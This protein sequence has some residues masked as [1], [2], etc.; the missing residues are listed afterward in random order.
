MRT[1]LRV[2]IIACSLLLLIAAA[3]YLPGYR[4]ATASV[5]VVTANTN[6]EAIGK[7]ES[8]AA[9]LKIYA[10][11]KGFNSER[12]F[13][14]DMS[15]PSGKQRFFVYNFSTDKIEEAGLVTHGSGSIT[16]KQ[17]LFFSNVPGSNCTS[18]GRY[19]IGKPYRGR[20]GLAYK[21]F[22]LDE[23]NSKAFERFVVLHSHGCV[24]NREVYPLPIC[25]SLGCP[26]VAPA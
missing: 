5:T 1:H 21:L 22:G 3:I 15:I 25:P 7:L 17:E 11:A 9:M 19:K 23:T 12:C 16:G 10:E 26:T 2:V 20:F 6:R 24:P 14:I 18:L 4:P 8:Q 13:M